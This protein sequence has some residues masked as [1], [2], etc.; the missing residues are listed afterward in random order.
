[1]SKVNRGGNGIGGGNPSWKTMSNRT[2]YFG[3][4]NGWYCPHYSEGC[5]KGF[6]SK[7]ILNAHLIA[8][9]KHG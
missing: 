4:G 2:R 9:H 8:V 5:V 3:P 7:A 1:M 6:T